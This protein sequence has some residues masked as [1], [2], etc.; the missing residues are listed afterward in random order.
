DIVAQKSSYGD[1]KWVAEAKLKTGEVK[2][3]S[4]ETFASNDPKAAKDNITN[5]VAKADRHNQKVLD[6]NSKML[7]PVV[8]LFKGND[9]QD[10]KKV[11]TLLGVGDSIF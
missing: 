8:N 6:E 10:P 2:V 4:Y 1:A 3:S 5:A 9:W 7:A 11:A